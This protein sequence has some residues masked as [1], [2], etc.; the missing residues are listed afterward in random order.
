M[1]EIT[2]K[3]PEEHVEFFYQLVGQLGYEKKIK[4]PA[5]KK[6]TEKQRILAN[7]EQGLK[8][9]KLVKEGKLKARDAKDLLNEL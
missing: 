4:K 1:K 7:I 9:L 2:V 8:E 5:P 3:V 6:M